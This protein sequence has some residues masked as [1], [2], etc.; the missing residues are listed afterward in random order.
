MKILMMMRIIVYRLTLMKVFLHLV[1]YFPARLMSWLMMKTD[2]VGW[3]MVESQLPWIHPID[4]VGFDN[5]EKRT[6]I[7]S[8]AASPNS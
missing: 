1:L 5:Q 2:R 4:L 6:T 7:H 8:N 3:K